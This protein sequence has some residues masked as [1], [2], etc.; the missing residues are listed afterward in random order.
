MGAC[1]KMWGVSLMPAALTDVVTLHGKVTR[2]GI[3][4]S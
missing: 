1:L 3:S 4:V 2:Q